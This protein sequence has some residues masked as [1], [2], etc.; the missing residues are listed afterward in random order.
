MK[1]IGQLTNA[2]KAKLLHEL[3]PAEMPDF[4]RYAAG[5]CSSIKEDEQTHRAKWDNGL[6][7]FDFWLSLANDTEKKI[8]QYGNKLNNNS[9]LFSD[10]L[11]EGYAAIF[12]AHC[13]IVYT[14]TRQHP[15][16]KFT[17]AVELLFA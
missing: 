1:T 3:F 15:N 11:F 14:T 7:D 16:K 4:I 5:I 12:M 13:L 8:K 6:F 9:R 10:Q 2:E 17:L